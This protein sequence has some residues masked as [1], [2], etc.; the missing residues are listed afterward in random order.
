M[1]WV[2]LGQSS[3]NLWSWEWIGGGFN[4]CHANSKEEAIQKAYEMGV[5][6]GHREVTLL[7]DE[8]SFS[9]S[10][11]KYDRLCRMYAMD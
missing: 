1:T 7:P 8:R 6:K 3:T 10:M 4:S 5:A 11:E 9:D 2:R